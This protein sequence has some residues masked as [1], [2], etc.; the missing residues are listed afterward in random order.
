[1][2]K[3]EALAKVYTE[4]HLA[5][6]PSKTGGG[7]PIGISGGKLVYWDRTKD[8]SYGAAHLFLD[9][10]GWETRGKDE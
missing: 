6:R 1:M 9:E 3:R 10:Q 8:T 5:R 7:Y 2:T 4:D